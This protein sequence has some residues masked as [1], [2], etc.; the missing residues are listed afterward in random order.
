[1]RKLILAV[2][3]AV[4]CP[5][6][7][8]ADELSDLKAQLDAAM[9]SIQAV[10]A[11]RRSARGGEGKSAAGCGTSA[12]GGQG[13]PSARSRGGKRGGRSGSCCCTDDGRG[14]AG[15]RA[16]RHAGEGGTGLEQ[17]ALGDQRQGAAGPHLRLQAH[18]SAL[19]R[20][21]AAVA[22]P[23]HL[24]GRCRLR[25]R[26]ARPSSAS[27]RARSRS[28]ATSRPRLGELKTDL[29]FDLFGTGGGN[30]TD[31]PAQR[32]GRAREV[33]SGAV[34]HP[35]HEH[36]HLPEH[37]RLLGTQRHD[38]PAQSAGAL[39]AHRSHRHEAGVFA[40]GSQRRHRYREGIRRRPDAGRRGLDPLAGLR[41]QFDS[42]RRL[43]RIP[44]RRDLA[45]GRLP[46][47]HHRQRQPVRHG[48]RM[49]HQRQRLAEHVRQGPDH[50]AA[51]L[52]PRHRELHERRRRRYRAECEPAGAG[53]AVD[54]RLR[55]L[56]PL[57][58]R[59]VEQLARLER[60][61]S[62]QHRR[63]AR[64][65]VQARAATPRPTCCGIRRRT[66]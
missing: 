34:L 58:E 11:T 32:L 42:Q 3:F 47:N 19:E 8:Q 17:G 64:Q 45:L 21:G 7:C 13:G 53:G 65:R 57:L 9:K 44:D 6:T 62:G 1:M 52:R 15:R 33:R 49:G 24:S 38:V 20:H 27:G 25:H 5:V 39:Y 40:R 48:D 66:C 63:T 60:A 43:G 18:E 28:R 30:T 36:R 23:G 2:A 50:G 61:S 22:D 4:A 14:S 55:V 41:G 10:E 26:T 59:Q 12:G 51:R 31:P 54:R 46:D 16:R 37:H 56:R 29:S 35:V